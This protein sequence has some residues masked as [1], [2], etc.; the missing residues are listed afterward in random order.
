[1]RRREFIT[2][3][4]SAAAAWSPTA[5]AQQPPT[6]IVGYLD[7]GAPE[8][9][10]SHAEF[11]RKGLSQT[12]Y[13]EDRNVVVVYRW[14]RNQPALGIE[15]AAELARLHVNVIVTT[16]LN[17]AFRA[18]GVTATIPIV[19]NAAGDPVETGLVAS[20]SRPGANVTGVTNTGGELG[21]KRLGLLRELVPRAT[22]FALLVNPV[23]TFAKPMLME[24]KA[25]AAAAGL[26]VE[27]VTA[28]TEQQIDE[29]FAKLAQKGTEALL[30]APAALFENR[31]MQLVRLALHYG[32]PTIYPTR[33]YA[34]VGGLMS[35]GASWEDQFRQVGV[36]TGRI[37]KGE[38]PADLP[39]VQP[40]KFEFLL[41]LKTAKALDLA[42]PPTL[43]A[44]AD[45]VIE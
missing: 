21:A 19:F 4:G 10:M 42:V 41:N 24:A 9:G 30:V 40:T 35:Y 14:G 34:E 18:K 5:R 16:T 29:G 25:A 15:L 28:E 2:L 31:R 3:I 45:E 37:L 17:G 38:K 12:G 39:V 33:E 23:T 43:R 8:E 7:S 27:A 44:L 1:M 13:H 36:Y 22:H 6:P 20:L 32:I 26:Q 11:F